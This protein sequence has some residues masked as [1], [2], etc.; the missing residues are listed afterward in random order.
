MVIIMIILLLVV[1][2]F[3]CCCWLVGM[4][5]VCLLASLPSH[6]PVYLF[7]QLNGLSH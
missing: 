4:L 6:M 7:R 3:I 2:L 1:L 5:V